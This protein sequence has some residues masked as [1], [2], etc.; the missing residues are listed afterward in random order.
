MKKQPKNSR[1]KVADPATSSTEPKMLDHKEMAEVM[2]V[3]CDRA[4]IDVSG[5]SLDEETK[6]TLSKNGFIVENGKTKGNIDWNK[7]KEYYTKNYPGLLEISKNKEENGVITFSPRKKLDMGK[8][9]SVSESRVTH[10]PKLSPSYNYRHQGSVQLPAYNKTVEDYPELSYFI[11]VHSIRNEDRYFFKLRASDRPLENIYRHMK[12][13]SGRYLLPH[14]L[15][16]AILPKEVQELISSAEKNFSKPYVPSSQNGLAPTS[17]LLVPIFDRSDK[18]NPYRYIAVQ[19]LCAPSVLKAISNVLEN[20]MNEQADGTVFFCKFAPA[21]SNPQ[22]FEV[23]LSPK[24][25]VLYAQAPKNGIFYNETF[26]LKRSFYLWFKRQIKKSVYGK[27]QI[28]NLEKFYEKMGRK[29]STNVFDRKS[30]VRTLHFFADSTFFRIRTL[31][32]FVNSTF[33]HIRPTQ[34]REKSQK[35]PSFLTKE[36]MGAEDW[37]RI[38]RDLALSLERLL[39]NKAKHAITIIDESEHQKWVLI[40]ETRLNILGERTT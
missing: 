34:K 2:G 11:G 5:K 16:V 23:G 40:L 13:N 25:D 38:S 1:K 37:S 15:N 22:N 27:Q 19:P 9:S 30:L 17:Q 6:A 35:I 14:G 7:L 36:K 39:S 18:T 21:V 20:R 4:K 33:Y 10:G 26:M 3:L 28:I 31:R 32:E 12:K 24:P 8:L 29:T